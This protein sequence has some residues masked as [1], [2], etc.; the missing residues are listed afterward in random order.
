MA[1]VI[2]CGCGWS[3]RAESDEELVKETQK[4]VQEVH[5]LMARRE[6]ILAQARTE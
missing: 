1:K 4:H 2:N 6:L 3:A 5:H